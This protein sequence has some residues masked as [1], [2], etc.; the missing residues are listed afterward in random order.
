MIPTTSQR[1]SFN[2]ELR[3]GSYLF[4]TVITM[5]RN[6]PAPSAAFMWGELDGISFGRVLDEYY[7]EVVHWK[8]TLSS[9]G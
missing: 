2:R 6:L 4:L 1:I 5:S 7:E 3:M 8:R 9:C